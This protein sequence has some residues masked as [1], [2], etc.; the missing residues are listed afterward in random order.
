MSA[1]NTTPRLFVPDTLA[2]G[3]DIA[4]TPAQ[5]HYLGTVMRQGPGAD[6]SLFNGR[7]GEFLARITAIRRDRASFTVTRQTRPQTPEPDL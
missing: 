4:A 2:Q 7:D 5:A 6:V 1:S 3:A